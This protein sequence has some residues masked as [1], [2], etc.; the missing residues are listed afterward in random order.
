MILLPDAIFAHIKVV[1]KGKRKTKE[2]RLHFDSV[3]KSIQLLVWILTT[4]EATLYSR[5]P[6]WD[7]LVQKDE[8]INRKI[9]LHML[10]ES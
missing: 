4:D 9:K 7:N 5:R 8:H 10:L 1:L 3:S 6:G 2:T